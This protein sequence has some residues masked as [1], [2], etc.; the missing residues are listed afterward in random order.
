M[1]MMRN[2]YNTDVLKSQESRDESKVLASHDN[3]SDSQDCM[4]DT[5]QALPRREVKGS[6]LELFYS[7]PALHGV[8]RVF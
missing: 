3:G 2:G 6:C 4:A 5:T 8:I 1:M 7:L